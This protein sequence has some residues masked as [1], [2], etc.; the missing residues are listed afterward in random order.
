MFFLVCPSARSGNAKFFPILGGQG[1][2]FFLLAVFF[3]GITEGNSVKSGDE[4]RNAHEFHT[5]R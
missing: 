3:I 5:Y 2:V 4:Q 1:L